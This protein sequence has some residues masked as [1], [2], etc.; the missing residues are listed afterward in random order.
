MHFIHKAG[1]TQQPAG[2]MLDRGHPLARG[3]EFCCIAN[4]GLCNDTQSTATPQTI[5]PVNLVN[6]TSAEYDLTAFSATKTPTTFVTPIGVA[7]ESAVW[8]INK[9]NTID[10]LSAANARQ[11]LT[12]AGIVYY[13][14]QFGD[15]QL[16]AMG[17]NSGTP[18]SGFSLFIGASSG[19]TF[20]LSNNGTLSILA[21]TNVLPPPTNTAYFLAGTYDGI[22]MTVYALPLLPSGGWQTASVV[23]LD[24]WNL[25]LATNFRYI[26][27]G[28]FSRTSAAPQNPHDAVSIGAIWSRCLTASEIYS[29]AEKP[30]QIILP[31]SA[32]RIAAIYAKFI[33]S[34]SSLQFL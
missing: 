30:Y 2:S 3:L 32:Q 17:G 11:P 16:L 23:K 28:G 19:A 13:N 20:T 15:T 34:G 33:Q 4:Q 9:L 8:A 22:T 24:G 21:S 1:Y 7:T 18:V 5:V 6:N 26:L 29:F 10:S 25:S 12:A 27:M 31:R 14:S